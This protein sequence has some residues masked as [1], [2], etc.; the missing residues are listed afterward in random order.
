MFVAWW[1]AV[2]AIAARATVP[3]MRDA[4]AR[5]AAWGTSRCGTGMPSLEQLLPEP[6]AVDIPLRHGDAELG[7]A[8]P[9]A[10][11]RR[12][13]PAARGCRSR[14]SKHPESRRTSRSPMATFRPFLPLLCLT[15]SV[16]RSASS[17]PRKEPPRATGACAHGVLGLATSRGCAAPSQRHRFD[18]ESGSDSR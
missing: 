6:E 1:R 2:L 13:P 5:V 12:H 3:L 18:R 15:P 8:P 7:A 14:V 4:L 17:L 16:P 11:G 9:R 10:G